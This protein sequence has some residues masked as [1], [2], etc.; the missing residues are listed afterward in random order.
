MPINTSFLT[1]FILS[2]LGIRQA[3]C[4]YAFRF[5]EIFQKIA[6]YFLRLKSGRERKRKRER[7]KERK[8][9][10]KKLAKLAKLD[11]LEKKKESGRSASALSVLLPYKLF[12]SCTRSDSYIFISVIIFIL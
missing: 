11:Q 7:K 12:C 6:F 10:T 2:F 1:V 5:S 4:P 9:K 3:Y 8:R